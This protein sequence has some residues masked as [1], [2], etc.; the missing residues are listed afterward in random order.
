[1]PN[2]ASNTFCSIELSNI[3][4]STASSSNYTITVQTKDL[5]G[6]VME[7]PTATAVFTILP[8]SLSLIDV[9]DN[10]NYTGNKIT[11]ING[12]CG[13]TNFWYY[14]RGADIYSNEIS[15]IEHEISFTNTVAYI[16]D[17]SA[18]VSITTNN[19]FGIFGW[20][21]SISP[22]TLF[23]SNTNNATKKI[24]VAISTGDM[25]TV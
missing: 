3:I 15:G 12:K 6:E 4:N 7:G 5:Y 10:S 16:Y 11:N 2:L 23:I 19:K 13:E 25:F 24:S 21:S 1:M 17:G 20:D 14:I 18:T 8:G 22:G 9:Y